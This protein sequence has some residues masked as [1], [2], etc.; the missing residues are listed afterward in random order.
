[1]RTTLDIDEDLILAAKELA[2]REGVTAGQV[3]SRL[4]RRALSGV[5]DTHVQ[6]RR[7]AG[8]IPFPAR[9]GIVATN[10]EVETLRDEEGI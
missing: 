1:M 4:L 5:P 9:P 6:S 10:A 3:V 7:G 2:R 8:F